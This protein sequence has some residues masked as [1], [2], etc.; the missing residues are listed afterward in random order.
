MAR[1]YDDDHKGNAQ[2]PRLVYEALRYISIQAPA[3][4][5]ASSSSAPSTSS[6]DDDD[7]ANS[8]SSAEAP[9]VILLKKVR[10]VRVLEP[11]GNAPWQI[12]LNRADAPGG[13]ADE[14]SID[15]RYFRRRFR[16]PYSLFKALIQVCDN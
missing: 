11:K 7:M 4:M 2:S 16:I 9:P 8:V 13:V 10:R 12:M 5:I 14:N 15:G 1:D 6:S 3:V